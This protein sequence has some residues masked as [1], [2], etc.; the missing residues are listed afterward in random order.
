MTSYFSYITRLCVV[1]VKMEVKPHP[2]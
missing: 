2:K 1:Y